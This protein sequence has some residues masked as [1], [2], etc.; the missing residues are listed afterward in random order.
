MFN[1]KYIVDYRSTV[2]S[3]YSEGDLDLELYFQDLDESFNRFLDLPSRWTRDPA[4]SPVVPAA[5]DLPPPVPAVPVQSSVDPPVPTAVVTKPV[6]AATPPVIVEVAVGSSGTSTAVVSETVY[7]SL[8][9]LRN[10]PR[11]ELSSEQYAQIAAYEKAFPFSKG[12]PLRF[13]PF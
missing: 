7:R 12:K 8:L 5:P 6:V 2:N 13:N 3:Y 11:A 4:G 9:K 1:N 10:D